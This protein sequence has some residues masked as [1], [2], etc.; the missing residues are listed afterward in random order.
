MAEIFY[1]VL[2]M[3]ILGSVCLLVVLALRCIKRIPRSIVYAAWAIP[4]LRW[5]VKRVESPIMDGVFFANA[6]QAADSYYP[7][8][9]KSAQLE[10]LFSV[11]GIIWAIIGCALLLTM[12]ILYYFTHRE[13]RDA[14]RL[15]GCVYQTDRVNSPALY[16]I[17][18]PRILVPPGMD[19][20]AMRYAIIHEDAHRRRGDNLFRCLMLI[21]C[22]VHWFNPLMWLSLNAVFAD[23]E[24]STD[25][26]VLRKLNEGERKAYALMLLDCIK[27]RNV[28]VAALGGAKIKVRV[29]NILI[30]KR[31]GAVAMVASL[32]L[33]LSLALIL[34]T[35]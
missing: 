24:L 35:N 30:Y 2:N 34:I 11:C 25:E 5:L 9:Y 26:R 16:G 23:M 6:L 4:F 27:P 17:F 12:A 29:N 14:K 21:L 10:R 3:S 33:L 22:C 31:M 8:S 13:T 32:I 15:Y 1:R 28:L 18:R 20:A 19:E 7:I